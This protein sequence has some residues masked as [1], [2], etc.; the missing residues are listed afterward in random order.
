MPHSTDR[1]GHWHFKIAIV[2][3]GISGIGMAV[4]LRRAGLPDF[5]VFERARDYGGVWQH[6]SYPGAACDIPSYLYS[7]S[8]AQQKGWSRP[9]S[10]QAEILEYL[11]QI[12]RENG[13]DE[14]VRCG[15][16]ITSAS[17]DETALAWTLASADRVVCTCD[18]LVVAC[19][20]LS[21]PAIPAIPGLERFRGRRF[22]SAN[23]DH[24]VELA[25]KRVAVVGTGA[26][27][28]Q[29][30]PPVATQAAHLDV[31]QRSAP[32]MLP[33]RN[34]AYGEWFRRLNDRL[35]G[36]QTARR[37]GLWMLSELM[38]AAFVRA[39]AIGSLIQ[40]WATLFMRRQVRDPELRRK[41][42]PDYP[43]G[44]KRV[45]FSSY[46]LPALQRS[47]VEL[48]TDPIERV[49]GTAVV[50]SDGLERPAD[51]IVFGTGFRANDFV[52]PMLVKGRNG[53]NL[54]AAW[55]GGAQAHHGISVSGFP[56]MFLLYGPNTNLGSGSVIMMIEAQIRYVIQAVRELARS[57]S[58]A[59]EVK[60]EVEAGS[61]A[62]VQQRLLDTVWTSCG[63]WYRV[64][65]T[66][67]VTNNWPGQVYEYQRLVRHF[68][69]WSYRHLRRL[70]E[71]IARQ[72]SV[73][74]AV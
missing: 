69:A 57:D 41:V 37:N 56:N 34:P 30:V 61:T 29:L 65:G 33:R 53:L 19:G 1:V 71:T 27:A 44:C 17:F 11:H 22:H 66:G 35:P 43:I 39:P 36:V 68:D 60:P 23:W 64:E 2:G 38:T 10:P 28:I 58:A 25:G 13:V 73:A 16:E 9:C 24:S 52:A 31:Y 72:P 15:I 67:R 46:Y 6:N 63:S 4:Q 7:Y 26:S 50:T 54:D 70:D 49:T 55:A 14:Q 12:A 45:L 40:A 21:R 51:V 3:A 42:W 47:N 8:F 48:V 5:V 62:A 74:D 32:W 59:L 18:V 20:Q